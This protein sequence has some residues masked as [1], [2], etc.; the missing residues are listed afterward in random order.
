MAVGF[1]VVAAA[2]AA[3]A[4]AAAAAVVQSQYELQVETVGSR[5]EPARAKRQDP[6]ERLEHNP[7]SAPK[8][9]S[10]TQDLK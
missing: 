3:T 7:S 1:V 8:P 2:A 10:Q 4:A 9:M 5:W 6:Q